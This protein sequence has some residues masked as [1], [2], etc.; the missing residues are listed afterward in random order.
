MRLCVFNMLKKKKKKTLL[1]ALVIILLSAAFFVCLGAGLVFALEFSEK[2]DTARYTKLSKIDNFLSY[3]ETEY[4]YSFVFQDSLLNNKVK[5]NDE[6]YFLLNSL[7]NC[8]QA[9]EADQDT[10]SKTGAERRD[11]DIS[12]IIIY[13]SHYK[14]YEYSLTLGHNY[15]KCHI[16]AGGRGPL[17]SQAHSYYFIDKTTGKQMYDFVRNKIKNGDYFFS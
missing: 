16:D 14:K 8:P 2:I 6:D 9:T 1:T 15:T 10:W 3:S 4:S 12:K 7:K 13:C 17:S 5:I 11:V